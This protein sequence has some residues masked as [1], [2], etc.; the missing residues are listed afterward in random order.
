MSLAFQDQR[1][2][3]HISTPLH[4]TDEKLDGLTLNDE[5]ADKYIS[6]EWAKRHRRL[7][8]KTA[9]PDNTFVNYKRLFLLLIFS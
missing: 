7:A 5:E 6:E 2:F 9:P 8:Y 4:F 1:W 3:F